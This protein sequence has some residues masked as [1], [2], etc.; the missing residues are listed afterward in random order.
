MDTLIAR[1]NGKAP[2]ITLLLTFSALF[3]SIGGWIYQLRANE[4]EITE[5]KAE[6]IRKDLATAQY[7]ALQQSIDDVKRSLTEMQRYLLEHKDQ[8]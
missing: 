8:R 2:G 6:Y 1:L 4:C 7:Q 5:I 3:I